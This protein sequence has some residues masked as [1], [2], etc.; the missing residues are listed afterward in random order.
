VDFK[1]EFGKNA[2]GK[3][4]L[5]DEITPDSCRLW[6]IKTGKKL[7]KDVFRRD[8]GDVSEGYFEV[9]NRMKKTIKK[10]I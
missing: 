3:I 9:Y 1:L 10:N 7:D 6:D 4:V 8:L 5:G 2:K